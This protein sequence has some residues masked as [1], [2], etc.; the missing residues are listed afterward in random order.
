MSDQDPFHSAWRALWPQAHPEK[1]EADDAT[2]GN[3]AT[4]EDVLK[5]TPPQ[6]PAPI[7]ATPWVAPE[8]TAPVV[9]E[10]PSVVA[11]APPDADAPEPVARALDETIPLLTEVLELPPELDDGLPRT[12]DEVD[13]SRLALQVREQVLDDLLRQ[14]ERFL[15]EPLRERV[16]RVVERGTR[17]LAIEIRASVEESVREAIALAVAEELTRVQAEILYRGHTTRVPDPNDPT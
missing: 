9:P 1:S 11:A 7:P 4:G 8:R 14:P 10:A 5:R 6:R 2:S 3:D 12:L 17:A 15:D 16:Q 13:W